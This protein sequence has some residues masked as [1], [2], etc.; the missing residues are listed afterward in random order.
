LYPSSF[1]YYAPE[2]LEEAFGIL[3]RFDGEA[4]VLAGG[5]SLIPVLKLRAFAAP[6]ALVDINRIPDLDTLTVT[7]DG[8]LRIGALVR[9]KTC[10]RSDLLHGKFAT[11]GH[12]IHRALIAL[13]GGIGNFGWA[14]IVL[15]FFVQVLLSPLTVTSF[16]HSQKMKAL[17]PQMKKLQ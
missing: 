7:R 14:I 15:T 3:E 11:L 8:G 17:Q 1:E 4:K 13:K 10:E 5:Q 9:H 2:T 16:K 12:W 6:A